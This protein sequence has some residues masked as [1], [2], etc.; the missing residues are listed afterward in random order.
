[1]T[2]EHEAKN[3][4]WQRKKSRARYELCVGCDSSSGMIARDPH[5]CS[6]DNHLRRSPGL[7]FVSRLLTNAIRDTTPKYPRRGF[8]FSH[9][10]PMPDWR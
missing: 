2:H 10:F 1:V 5:D 3:E 6:Q 7:D 9:R 8:D 4:P